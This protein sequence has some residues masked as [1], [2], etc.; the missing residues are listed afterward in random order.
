MSFSG[1]YYDGQVFK[2]SDGPAIKRD[3]RLETALWAVL[4]KEPACREGMLPGEAIRA[5]I[6][7]L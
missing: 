6:L 3:E 4:A 5:L 1:L 7:V 2:Q